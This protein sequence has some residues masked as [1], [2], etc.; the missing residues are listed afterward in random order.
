MASPAAA[1]LARAEAYLRER[2]Y[3]PVSIDVEPP[4]AL[5]MVVVVPCH[6]EPDI[7]ST[8]E[9]LWACRRPRV[10]VEAIVN[11]NGSQADPPRARERSD[12]KQ[13]L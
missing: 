7:I 4:S 3:A 10:A 11:V 13:P 2:A 1:R 9:S 5:G 6:D 8:L 12:R